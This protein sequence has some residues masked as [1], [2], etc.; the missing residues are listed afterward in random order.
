MG[1]G[2]LYTCL[3]CGHNFTKP[4]KAQ[5]GVDVCPNCTWGNITV[6]DDNFYIHDA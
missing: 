5:S 3:D 6:L 4:G 1:Y 2:K